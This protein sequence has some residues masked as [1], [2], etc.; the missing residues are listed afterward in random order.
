MPLNSMSNIE[1][2]IEN[3]SSDSSNEDIMPLLVIV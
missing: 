3:N 2:N 1:I